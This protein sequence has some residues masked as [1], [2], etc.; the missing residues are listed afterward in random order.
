MLLLFP[1]YMG[2]ENTEVISPKPFKWK[3]SPQESK[4]WAC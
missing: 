4:P 2:K 3:I 1:N